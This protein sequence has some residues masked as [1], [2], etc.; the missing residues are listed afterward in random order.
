MA[1]QNTVHPVDNRVFSIREVMLMMSVP[2][3]F[4]WSELSFEQLNALPLKEK[5]SFLKK[6]EMN[7]RQS[8]G[9]AVPTIIFRQIAC[10]VKKYY[11]S[12]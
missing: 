5:E 12:Q 10:K 4:Q 7:I 3:S 11:V 6:E 2:A 1:S 8:L 9:E